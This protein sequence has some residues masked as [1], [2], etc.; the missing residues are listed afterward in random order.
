MI[1]RLSLEWPDPRPFRDRGGAPLLLLA[2]SDQREEALSFEVNREALG[3]PDLIVGCGDLDPGYLRFVADA[4][5]CPMVFVRGNHDRGGAWRH[6]VRHLPEP[7]TGGIVE[8]LTDLHLAALPWPARERRRDEVGAWG[9]AVGVGLRAL[10]FRG[11]PLL[12]ASHAPPLGAGD[13]DDD[14]YHL[15]FSAYRRLASWLRPPLWL[16]GH[17]P[18]AAAPWRAELGPTT[19]VNVT[20]AV[21]VELTPPPV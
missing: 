7:L 8:P 15:G 18:L 12:V 16:H 14:P 10:R 21:S 6:E 19:L 3:R 17:S 1:R 2:L 9:Q 20:G 4:F 5:R 13:V 11:R